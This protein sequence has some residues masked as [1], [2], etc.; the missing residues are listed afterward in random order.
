MFEVGD[1]FEVTSYLGSD[2][3]VGAYSFHRG[4]RIGETG[5]ITAVGADVHYENS[6]Q[7]NF[8]DGNCGYVVRIE[9]ITRF[10]RLEVEKLFS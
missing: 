1:R 9:E 5:V 10:P 7:V 4:Y 6:V 8:D 3:G 2:G